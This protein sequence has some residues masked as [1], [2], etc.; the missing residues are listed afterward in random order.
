M[1]G[2]HRSGCGGDVGVMAA[3]GGFA[4]NRGFFKRV[5]VTGGAGFI[6]SHVV[7][8]FVKKY[9][10]YLVI[11]LDKLDYCASLKNLEAISEEPNYK[12][13]QGDICD[14]HFIK[15]LFETENINIV[16]HYAAQTHVDISFSHSSEFSNTNIYGTSVLV[17]AA[18]EA[19][20]EK[21]IYIST[22]EVY[23]GSLDEEFDELSP[24]R[25]TNPYAASKAAAE[26]CVLSY[27]EKYKFPVIVTR[28]CNIYGPHQFPGKVIPKFISLLQRNKKCS[29]HGS[30]IQIRNFLYATDVVEAFFTVLKNGKPGEIYNIGTDFEISVQQ[31]AKELIRL[32]KKTKS[33]S[34]TEEWLDFVSDRP[35][36]EPKYPMKLEKI[37]T[38]GWRPKVTWDEGLK[39]TIEWYRDY[40]H[41][42]SN[43][44]EGLVPFPLPQ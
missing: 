28:S 31:L 29:I 22:D 23:G 34:E 20:V 37:H 43:A 5:L 35:F 6:A 8:A 40:F 12:F 30:G 27:W 17:D 19:N 36:L 13:I 25:P 1:C 16:L 24:K 42:W 21:F 2:E 15:L 11:N 38:L 41:N 7:I 44:E 26:C 39:K 10:D 9:P 3:P 4:P 32:I 18:Y 33:D 14:A